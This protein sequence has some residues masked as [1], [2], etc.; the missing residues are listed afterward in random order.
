MIEGSFMNT[1]RQ[2]AR[3]ISVATSSQYV[4]VAPFKYR[5]TRAELSLTFESRAS[6]LQ[7]NLAHRLPA[8][9]AG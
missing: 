3:Q 1:V 5:H 7:L 4:P 2:A 9:N 8:P 6:W